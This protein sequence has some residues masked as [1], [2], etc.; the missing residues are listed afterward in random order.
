MLREVRELAGLILTFPRESPPEI[1]M[2]IAINGNRRI[3]GVLPYETAPG[4]LRFRHGRGR[5][6]TETA[7]IQSE[8]E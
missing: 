5:F 6:L 2:C 1:G 8:V 7:P 3:S 4:V